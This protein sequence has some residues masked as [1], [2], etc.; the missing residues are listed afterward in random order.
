MFV[1]VILND[2][3]DKIN[4]QQKVQKLS[5]FLSFFLC[6]NSNSV[7]ADFFHATAI[8]T[9][10]GCRLA[11]RYWLIGLQLGPVYTFVSARWAHE[12]AHESEL[13]KWAVRVYTKWGDTPFRS[14]HTGKRVDPIRVYPTRPDPG[15]GR[16]DAP[17]SSGRVGSRF[18]DPRVYPRP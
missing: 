11:M 10:C 17:K 9:I 3:T 4:F 15:S 12:W 14:H 8:L 7:F 1:G 6:K 18:F 13:T 16:V 5:A 2:W